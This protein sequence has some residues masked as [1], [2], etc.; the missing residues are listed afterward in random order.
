MIYDADVINNLLLPL[1]SSVLMH[2]F[3]CYFK[4]NFFTVYGEI[5]VTL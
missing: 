2:L 3:S 4:K 5:L 1:T